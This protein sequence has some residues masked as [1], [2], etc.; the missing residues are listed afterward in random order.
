[1]SAPTTATTRRP[2]YV[3]AACT[4]D[5]ALFDPDLGDPEAAKAVCRGCALREACLE[6]AVTNGEEGVWGA[7]TEAERRQL[8]GAPVRG[9][10]RDRLRPQSPGSRGAA[11]STSRVPA[12]S[13]G[14]RR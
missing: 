8:G 12:P 13:S 7:T 4:Q 3:V 9:G 11:A 1:M 14:A 5:V 10:R 6:E 2:A